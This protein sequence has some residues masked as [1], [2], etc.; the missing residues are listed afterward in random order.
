[1]ASNPSSQNRIRSSSTS[2]SVPNS[3]SLAMSRCRKWVPDS[4]YLNRFNK[5]L[6]GCTSSR[7]LISS[8][9]FDERTF[10]LMELLLWL[11]KIEI[12][13]LLRNWSRDKPDLGFVWSRFGNKLGR[14]RHVVDE[15]YTRPQGLYQHK[16]V[17][18]KK[19]RKLILDSKLAP[20]PIQETTTASA[21]LKNAQFA[22]WHV[23]L[24]FMVLIVSIASFW[25]IY[26]IFWTI[27]CREFWIS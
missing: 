17:D 12:R 10:V 22:S 9:P 5:P 6:T 2:I 20:Y 3:L 27:F 13:V 14:K 1:M 26:F 25:S 18:H 21:I 24:I 15:K 4:I 19:L 7:P 16:D 8:P 23:L 11:K